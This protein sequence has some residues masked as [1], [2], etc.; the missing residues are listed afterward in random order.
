MNQS[1]IDQ[2]TAN[3]EAIHQSVAAAKDEGIRQLRALGV[4]AAT[5]SSLWELFAGMQNIGIFGDG[6]IIQ[7]RA[8]G[9]VFITEEVLEPGVVKYILRAYDFADGKKKTG[10][11]GE[12][13]STGVSDFATAGKRSGWI[14]E[15]TAMGMADFAEGYI[16]RS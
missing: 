13:T 10:W 4:D 1:V 11:R 16:E 7:D 5:S 14:R 3:I 2:L 12:R 8:F 15:H 9:E 6:A